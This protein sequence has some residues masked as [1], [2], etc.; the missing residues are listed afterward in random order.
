MHGICQGCSYL[1][2]QPFGEGKFL[3]CS[4]KPFSMSGKLW[5]TQSASIFQ[6]PLKR[7]VAKEKKKKFL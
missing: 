3:C 1:V 2:V 7:S 5:M 6:K 4:K